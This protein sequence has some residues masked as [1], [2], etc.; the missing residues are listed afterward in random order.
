[1]KKQNGGGRSAVCRVDVGD[2]SSTH[3]SSK[4]KQPPG[5]VKDI[6]TL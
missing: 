3:T 2:S 5:K 1:M 6:V 4:A